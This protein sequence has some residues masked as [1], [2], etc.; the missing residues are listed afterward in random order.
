MTRMVLGKIASQSIYLIRQSQPPIYSSTPTISL[1]T[2]HS[3][4]AASSS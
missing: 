2:V 1:L 3:F 4:L